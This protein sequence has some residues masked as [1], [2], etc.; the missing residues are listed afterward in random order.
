MLGRTQEDG[1][2][3]RVPCPEPSKSDPNQPA[4][5]WPNTF[6]DREIHAQGA[7]SQSRVCADQTLTRHT[8]TTRYGAA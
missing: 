4:I 3:N 7:M 5:I 1:V 6:Q 8:S 2:P